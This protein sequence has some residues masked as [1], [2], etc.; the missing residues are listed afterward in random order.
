M[1]KK[2]AHVTCKPATNLLKCAFIYHK[3]TNS[4]GY[5]VMTLLD[6]CIEI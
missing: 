5:M 6:Q 1:L 2:C 3:S 4:D